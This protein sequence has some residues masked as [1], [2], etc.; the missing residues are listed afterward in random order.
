MG[1]CWGG[2]RVWDRP[3]D[4]DLRAGTGRC[5][6]ICMSTVTKRTLHRAIMAKCM[7]CQGEKALVKQCDQCTCPLWVFRLPNAEMD[8]FGREYRENWIAKS[9]AMAKVD[10]T[11]DGGF[12][13]SQVRSEMEA[14]GMGA[15]AHSSWIDAACS[16]MRT[17]A[18][19][20]ERFRRCPLPQN[21]N[22]REYWYAAKS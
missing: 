16:N 20:T 21:R 1:V 22:R 19:R 4:L 2:G 13:P 10:I 11:T 3:V 17:W 5:S 8:L 15:P 9:R 7:R 6:M 14:I 12:W 18:K